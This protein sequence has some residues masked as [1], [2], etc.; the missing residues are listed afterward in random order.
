MAE[1]ENANNLTPDELMAA[2]FLAAG[3]QDVNGRKYTIEE[4]CQEV[5][6]CHPATF[7]R[8]QVKQA[9]KQQVLEETMGRMTK[10]IPAMVQAQVEKSIKQKDTTAFMAIMR[11]AGLLKADKSEIKT[12]VHT[13]DDSLSE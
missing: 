11:Q 3:K 10:F 5:L 9:F 13:I 1:L 7:Y 12:E 8:M 2:R 6:K 4:F